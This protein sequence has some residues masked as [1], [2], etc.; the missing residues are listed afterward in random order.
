[1]L[2]GSL[3]GVIIGLAMLLLAGR[4]VGQERTL[5]KGLDG[6]QEYKKQVRYRLIPFVW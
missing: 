6:Y 5:V 4:I 3:Y 2:L 1:M